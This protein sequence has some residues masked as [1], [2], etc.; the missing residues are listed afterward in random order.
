ML[1]IRIAA[2]VPTVQAGGNMSEGLGYGVTA[3]TSLARGG[4]CMGCSHRKAKS[5]A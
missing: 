1:R 5:R 4:R 3:I 2:R